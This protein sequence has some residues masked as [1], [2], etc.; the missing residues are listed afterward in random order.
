MPY[1]IHL[2]ETE[3]EA[4]ETLPDLSIDYQVHKSIFDSA[5]EFHD[6]QLFY[7]MSDFYQNATFLET[8]VL[9][10]RGEVEQ[11]RARIFSP[12]AT[13]AM[14]VLAKLCEKA[15]KRRLSIYAFGES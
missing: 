10:L 14:S 3:K 8:H 7:H 1:T 15:I 9:S 13:E 6:L 5:A 11:A 4:R 2:A 12:R